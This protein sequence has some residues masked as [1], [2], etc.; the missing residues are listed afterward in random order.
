MHSTWPLVSTQQLVLVPEASF[1][2]AFD[3]RSRWGSAAECGIPCLL[4]LPDKPQHR[5]AP[6][7]VKWHTELLLV[8]EICPA[9]WISTAL[10]QVVPYWLEEALK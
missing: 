10:V 8:P 1:Q 2:A 4:S 9:A 6:P 3:P 7:P 5:M